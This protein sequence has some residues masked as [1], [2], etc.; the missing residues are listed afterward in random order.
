MIALDPAL[1]VLCGGTI[2]IDNGSAS[3]QKLGEWVGYSGRVN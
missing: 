2:Y 3:G 1:I